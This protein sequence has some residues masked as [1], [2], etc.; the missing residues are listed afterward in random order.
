MVAGALIGTGLPVASDIASAAITACLI[1]LLFVTFLDVPFERMRQAF[2]EPKFLLAVLGLNF[3]VVPL[4]VA[5]LHRL[6]PLDASLTV[7]ALIVLLSPCID[8]VLVF[9]K[10]AGGAHDRLLVLTPVLMLAQI[11]LLPLYLWMIIGGSVAESLDPEPF[12]TALVLFI[13]LPLL[14]ALLIR[15]LSRSVGRVRRSASFAADSMV[16]LMMLT[17]A[18]IAAAVTPVISGR[19]RELGLAMTV[20]VLFAVIMTGLGWAGSR[21]LNLGTA[22]ARALIFT[23]VTRNSLVM[24]PIVRAIT[25]DG[26]G[27]A[28]VVAQTLVELLVMVILVRCVRLIAPR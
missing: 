4:V 5:G 3:V 9:T 11:V 26:V 10:L 19:L 23:G 16:A 28:V 7:P 8:Y 6:I 20:F 22:D 18:V 14:A 2:A 27:P 24:L 15:V 1:A 12:L 17:L 13:V 21:A 25:P